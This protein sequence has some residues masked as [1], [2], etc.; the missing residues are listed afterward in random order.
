MWYYINNVYTYK[1]GTLVKETKKEY[2]VSDDPSNY[3]IPLGNIEAERD[4]GY[5]PDYVDC[6]IKMI[7]HSQPG[8]YVV[9][10]GEKRTVKDFILTCIDI[11]GLNGSIYDYITIDP[12]FYRPLDV[13]SLCADC[14]KVKEVLDWKPETSFEEMVKKMLGV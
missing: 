10:T 9:G 2:N 11:L 12:R 1:D 4:W 3:K 7:E 14:T 8:D 5:A 6:M 13:Q